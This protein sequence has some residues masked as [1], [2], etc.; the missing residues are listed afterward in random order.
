MIM[1]QELYSSAITIVFLIL[2]GSGNS[3][4]TLTSTTLSVLSPK[5]DSFLRNDTHHVINLKKEINTSAVLHKKKVKKHKSL[6]PDY[7]NPYQP[8]NPL[9]KPL[10]YNSY[11]EKREITDKPILAGLL[12]DILTNKKQF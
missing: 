7:Y 8:F 9:V 3:Q 12:K 5:T 11:K 2:T 10:P 1:K 4:I 6:Q